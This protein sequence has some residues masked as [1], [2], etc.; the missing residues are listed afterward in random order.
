ML[1]ENS[2]IC[3]TIEKC[4]PYVNDSSTTELF[5]IQDFE[6]YEDYEDYDEDD[7]IIIELD[8]EE[9][10]YPEEEY[11]EEDVSEE[12]ED[13]LNEETDLS[14]GCLSHQKHRKSINSTWIPQCDCKGYYRSV[15]CA[16]ESSQKS[17]TCWCSTAYGSR[18]SSSIVVDC[19]NDYS[20][21]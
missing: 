18:M 4:I 21:L 8:S 12:T 20:V 11:Q 17:L 13:V 2:T 3:E 6:D 9:E 1:E 14:P 16:V 7:D 10:E 5:N 19:T 15:Q